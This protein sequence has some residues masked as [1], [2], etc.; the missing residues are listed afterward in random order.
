MKAIESPTGR[1][2]VRLWLALVCFA[3]AL[4]ALLV[5]VGTADAA[6]VGGGIPVQFRAK[7]FE[8]HCALGICHAGVTLRYDGVPCVGTLWGRR[9]HEGQY[10][11]V[12]ATVNGWRLAGVRRVWR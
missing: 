4:L 7:L 2:Q 5:L 11:T 8:V 12:N 6:P 10:V 3:L 1:R 9:L